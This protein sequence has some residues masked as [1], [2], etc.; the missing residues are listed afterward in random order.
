MQEVILN[1]PEEE[2]VIDYTNYR[3]ERGLRRIRPLAVR[4]EASE[5]HPTKQWLLRAVD[6][7]KGAMRDFAMIDIH[8]WQVPA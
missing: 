8:S 6:V 1:L 5:W 4:F 3:G 7:E 2:V